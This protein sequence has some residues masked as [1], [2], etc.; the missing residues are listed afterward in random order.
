M[1]VEK[2]QKKKTLINLSR[3]TF[4]EVAVLLIV[5]LALSIALTYLLPKGEFGVLPDGST[6]YLQ[7]SRREGAAG[8]P[9]L[10]GIFAPVLVFFSS[11]GLTLAMLSLFLFVIALAKP[12][13]QET[14]QQRKPA[15]ES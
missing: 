13:P 5:L 7:F 14:M 2:S 15:K 11:D 3:K 8:I 4:L 1:T 6:D 10:Q 12:K 9:L